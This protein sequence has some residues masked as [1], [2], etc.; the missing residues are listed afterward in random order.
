[1]KFIFFFFILMTYDAQIKIFKSRSKT[2]HP[3]DWR[4]LHG[5]RQP[6]CYRDADNVNFISHAGGLWKHE[7]TMSAL[8]TGLESNITLV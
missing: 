7:H 5:E 4:P 6:L 3:I 8:F 2:S 1:M